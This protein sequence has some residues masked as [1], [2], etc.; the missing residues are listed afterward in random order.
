MSTISSLNDIKK[1][2]NL[3]WNNEPCVVLEAN[4]VRMQQRK[5]VMQTKLKNLISSKV[6]EYSFKQGERIEE[7]DL[8]RSKANYLYKDEQSAYF[9][10]NETYE[11]FDIPLNQLGS[12][13]KFLKEGTDCDIL[14]FE[15]K[16]INIDI[17]IKI[18]LK[19]ISAPPGIKGDSSSNVTKQ[20]ELETGAVINAPLFVKEGEEIIVNTETEEYVGRA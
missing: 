5:P 10:N 20:I 19:V 2:L 16:P 8:A 13:I 17:P 18:S 12:K 15:N 1:G 14:Y 6:V 7:A 11:Q 4:F 9:M 3:I